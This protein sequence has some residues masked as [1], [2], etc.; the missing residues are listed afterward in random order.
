MRRVLSPVLR[1]P[2]SEVRIKLT[3]GGKRGVLGSLPDCYRREVQF[4]SQQGFNRPYQVLL[5]LILRQKSFRATL[6]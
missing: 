6:P 1:A 4:T 2:V 3:V 5:N